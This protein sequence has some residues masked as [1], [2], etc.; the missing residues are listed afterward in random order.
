MRLQRL[1]NPRSIAF[2]GGAECAVAI[3]RTRALGFTGR[4]WAVNPRRRQLGAIETVP[5]VSDIDGSPDAAFIA[6]PRTATPGVVG[7]L[8]ALGCGG[9][10]IY[11][12]GFAE[13]G[14]HCLQQAL[15]AAAGAGTQVV[16]VGHRYLG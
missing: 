1:L 14:D 11:A 13:T 15:L 2:V 12:A 16:E 3:E 8:H 4:I 5:A 9:A 10:V 7:E 6:L